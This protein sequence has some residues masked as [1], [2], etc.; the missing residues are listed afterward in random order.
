MHYIGTIVASFIYHVSS[1]VSLV[2]IIHG[3]R[4]W[5]WD[6]G[7]DRCWGWHVINNR[8]IR[9]IILLPRLTRTGRITGAWTLFLV[10][11]H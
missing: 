4:N 1:C 5:C 10:S 8:S 6:W 7:G 9:V 11:L 3:G 2:R